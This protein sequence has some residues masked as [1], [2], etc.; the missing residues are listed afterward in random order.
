MVVCLSY[1]PDLLT[2]KTP[3]LNSSI[4]R[5]KFGYQEALLKLIHA[6]I[7]R[8]GLSNDQL[9]VRK[10]LDLCSFYGK[11]VLV[12]SQIHCPRVFTWNLM[13]RALTINGSSLQ[14]LLPYN[15]MIYNGFKPQVY[16]PV[17]Y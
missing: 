10:H 14:L 8:H 4:T 7:I 6:K 11:T 5:L 1:T 15:L 9:L 16:F 17:C 2:H 3:L 12:F 13:I